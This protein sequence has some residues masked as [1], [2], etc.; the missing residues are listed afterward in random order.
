[1]ATK[2]STN[3][4][5]DRQLWKLL[6]ETYHTMWRTR[7]KE[8]DAAGISM[9]QAGVLLLVSTSQDP[10]T[11]AVLSRFLYREPHTISGLLTRMEKQGLVKRVKDLK[12]KNQVRIV[13]T[14]KGKKACERQNKAGVTGRVLSTLTPEERTNFT[15]HL[16][17]L[18][19]AALKELRAQLTLPYA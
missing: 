11:P 7:E 13:L 9:I 5:R 8:L 16:D 3:V 4:D 15:N 2:G 17:K 19:K 14:E 1:M 6:S 10:V 12:R 18:K